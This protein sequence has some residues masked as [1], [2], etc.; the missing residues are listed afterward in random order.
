MIPKYIQHQGPTGPS[1]WHAPVL[2][3]LPLPVFIGIVAMFN[4]VLPPT[5]QFD[6]SLAFQ[7]PLFYAVLYTAFLACTYCIVAFICLNRYLVTG[8]PFLLLLG[9]GSF[10]CGCA[11]LL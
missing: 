3:A 2:S 6:R 5:A 10:Q 8:R 4:F 9:A 1:H 11:S 7:L